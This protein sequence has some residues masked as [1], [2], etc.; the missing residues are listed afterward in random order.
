[1]GPIGS[2]QGVKLINNALLTANL[3]IADDA[4]T[5][6]AALGVRGDAL[7]QWLRSGSGRSYAL[8]V[9]MGARASQEIRD[10]AR[11]PL[12]K[13]VHA[14]ADLSAQEDA[15]GQL[16]LA[17]AEEALRRMGDPPDGWT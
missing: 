8:D 4:L 5:L 12:E 16:L 9:V 1:M 7:A 17:A 3:A 2:A 11:P 10:A 15:E 13:D 14:L 6:G